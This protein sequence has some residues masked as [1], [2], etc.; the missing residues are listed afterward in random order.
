MKEQKDKLDSLLK[1]WI[2]FLRSEKPESGPED[3]WLTIPE[4]CRLLRC[5]EPTI[6]RKLKGGEISY[7][8]PAGIM[9]WLSDLAK[10][11]IQTSTI[12]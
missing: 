12:K 1:Q 11:V 2:L 10:Y 3:K 4:I 9:I 8:K 6:Y 5:S 7:S